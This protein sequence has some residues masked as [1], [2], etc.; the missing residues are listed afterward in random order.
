MIGEVTVEELPEVARVI[1]RTVLHSV[2]ATELEKAAFLANIERNLAWCRTHSEAVHL[3]F[4]A[5]AAIVGMV[6]VKDYWNLCHLFVDPAWQRRGIG[7]S[8]IAEAIARCRGKATRPAIRLNASRNAVSFY[9][10]LG[11]VRVLDAPAP[12]AG[13]QFEY[14]L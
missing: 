9:E 6:L 12:Y 2:D 5:D 4:S 11:F 10:A 3:K 7:K 14:V 8:L 1:R 13:I